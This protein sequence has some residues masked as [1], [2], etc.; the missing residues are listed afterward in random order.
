VVA[1]LLN[2]LIAE[3]DAL[4]DNVR[5]DSVRELVTDFKNWD[6]KARTL[7]DSAFTS[8]EPWQQYPS[9]FN[10][11]YYL[12]GWTQ[13][14]NAGRMTEGITERLRALTSVSEFLNLYEGPADVP[15]VSHDREV[16]IVHG[17]SHLRHSVKNFL[18]EA[19]DAGA[20]FLDEEFDGSSAIIEKLEEFASKAGFA[21]VLMTG[22]DYGGLVG[23]KKSQRRAR[24]NVIF[25]LGL[26][27]GAWSRKRVAILYEEGVERPSDIDGVLYT[28]LDPADAWKM[29]L[30][31]K[32]QTAGFTVDF[33]KI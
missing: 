27:M 26:F 12:S 14:V 15:T 25:E 31:K 21:I 16:F 33:N 2:R 24:Q 9:R 23:T 6:S 13:D 18:R 10:G 11:S 1:E 17:R 7:L 3:G 19:T 22:D 20:I 4:R 28:I 32:L 30:G 8:P 29:A 5:A